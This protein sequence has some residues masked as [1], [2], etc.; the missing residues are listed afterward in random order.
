MVP[1]R[2]RG[3]HVFTRMTEM[4]PLKGWVDTPLEE[5]QTDPDGELRRLYVLDMW[6]GWLRIAG[7]LALILLYA[8][9]ARSSGIAPRWDLAALAVAYAAVWLVVMPRAKPAAQWLVGGILLVGDAVLITVVPVLTGLEPTTWSPLWT[10]VAVHYVVRFGW[11]GGAAVWLLAAISFLIQDP[12]RAAGVY[13]AFVPP[14]ATHFLGRLVP[15]MS[16]AVLVILLGR[17]VEEDR[18]LRSRLRMMAIRDGLTGLYNHRHF[19]EV[20][21]REMA[22][23]DRYGGELSLLMIDLDEFKAL[24]DAYG[25][26]AGDEVLAEVARVIRRSIRVH[27]SA[28]RYGGEE[29]AVILPGAPPTVAEV[30]GTRLCRAVADH[31]FPYRQVTASVGWSHYPSLAKSAQELVQQ[32]D[33]A[34]YGA[35]EA[36]GN[37][38]WGYSRCSP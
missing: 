11:R 9:V 36:G 8:A 4:E 34:V 21:H 32:A 13:T 15:L 7:F 14:E 5:E 20:L 2:G 6:I 28:F 35:K 25:H 27:D 16:L 30:V 26:L 19:H 31:P 18:E 38:V 37:G 17:L 3:Q 33:Q 10:L 1:A 12:L 22:R 24:N 23:A 29:F